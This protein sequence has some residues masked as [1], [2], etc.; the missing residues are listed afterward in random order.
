[1]ETLEDK[2]A[3]LE[4]LVAKLTSELEKFKVKDHEEKVG[5]VPSY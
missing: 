2:V 5:P 1:M 4:G 3:Y